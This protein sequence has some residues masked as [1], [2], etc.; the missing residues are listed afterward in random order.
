[1]NALTMWEYITDME[2]W[3]L[4]FTS[5][6]QAAAFLTVSHFMAVAFVMYMDLSGRWTR[7]ALCQKRPSKT[8]ADYVPGLQSFLM[9]IV[10]LF[11]PTLTL[12]LYIQANRIFPGPNDVSIPRD[13]IVS[14]SIKLISGYVLGKIW[15]FAVHYALHHPTLYK[16]HK[17]HHQRP[18]DLVAS[19]AWD[20]SVVEYLVM[21]MPSFALVF[22]FF[23]TTMWWIHLCHFALHGIDG[24][25]GH[26]GFSAP[27]F[28]GAIFDGEYHYYHHA[29]L[30]VNYAELEFL[31]KFFGTHHSQDKRFVHHMAKTT[32]NKQKTAAA[33]A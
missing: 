23:P 10:I 18:A 20:D 2:R 14:S 6:L 31:D 28:L 4:A 26:S 25:V 29:H 17:K 1:M 16:Y 5:T 12:C 15:A 22:F 27:G 3:T 8:I 30:T 13:N 9:D 33:A 19:A 24:A 11:I 21:E 7:Y 32:L